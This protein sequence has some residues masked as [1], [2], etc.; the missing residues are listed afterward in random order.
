MLYGLASVKM[1]Q[2]WYL[3][4]ALPALLVGII[5]GPMAAKF[6]DSEKWGSA[7][8]YQTQYITL[9]RWYACFTLPRTP[10]TYYRV[11]PELL[12]A[13]TL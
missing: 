13:F 4:E 7:V 6:I 9:V 10:L 12:L 1:K 8:P 2:V 3:G 5:L 11:S